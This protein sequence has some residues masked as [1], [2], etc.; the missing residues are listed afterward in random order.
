MEE[1]K[2]KDDDILIEEPFFESIDKLN[3]ETILKEEIFTNYIFCIDN[4]IKREKEIAKL[5]KKARELKVK[6]IFDKAL[7]QYEK[8]Y[9]KEQKEIEKKQK[10]IEETKN[11]ETDFSKCI[12][13]TE[14]GYIF[15]QLKLDCGKWIANEEGVY[16]IE[17]NYGQP[18]KIEASPIPI[19]PIERIVNIETEIEKVRLALFKDNKWK[20]L[21]LNKNTIANKNK[22]L[23]LP[24]RGLDVIDD[25]AKYLITYLA[26]IL[27]LNKFEAKEGVSHLGW[28][29]KEF[30][31]YSSK[32]CIDIEYEFKQK[33][34][35][36]KQAGNYEEWKKYIK[37]LR[38]FSTTL[39]FM[40]ASSFASILIKIFNIDPVLVH[41]WGKSKKVGKTVATLVCASVWG[42]PKEIVSNLSNTFTAN[43]RLCNFYRNMPVFLNELQIAK[44]Q[45]S[46]FNQL[47]YALGEGKGK[48]RG[49]INDGLREISS[50]ENIIILNGEEPITDDGSNEGVKN[51]VIEINEEKTL[52]GDKKGN[53][54]V[55]F[56]QKNYGYAGPEFIRYVQNNLE[57]IKKLWC[58]FIN[59]L[60]QI[61]S[62][63]GQS[64]YFAAIMV[65]DYIISK[66]IFKDEAFSIKDIK[67]YMR[68]DT[69]ETDRYYNIILEWFYQNI[70]KFKNNIDIGD[71]WGK[72]LNDND[73]NVITIFINPKVLK[74]FL[75]TQNISWNAIKVKMFEKKYIEKDSKGQ[76]SVSQ[77]VNGIKGRYIKFLIDNERIAI[78]EEINY[79]EEQ[80]NMPF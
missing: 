13:G 10:L 36:I 34:R 65:A 4:I 28:I 66:E 15:S 64:N 57:E 8:E 54:I 70:N 24:D 77:K 9:K 16:K 17:Y 52:M 62:Y 23:Q 60:D 11:N 51:R 31:P 50:W 27:K 21:V 47:V 20:E 44:R 3:E 56:I 19:V 40:I 76:Y 14:K 42:K 12:D 46:D 53:E 55:N 30:V 74:D 75:N 48:E 38:S 32:Y 43:E 26:D 37:H 1:G 69:D 49:T 78:Q 73:G 72:Y 33:S 71:V 22:I 79:K 35:S 68:E 45:F 41:I 59:E 29:G 63:Q 5:Q 80:I 67:Q 6:P 25:N 58:N 2:L 7:K 18:I 39:R 61:N